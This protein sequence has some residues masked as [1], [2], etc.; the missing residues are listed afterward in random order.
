MA[1]CGAESMEE[2][3]G[4]PRN[5]D[6]AGMSDKI[7]KVRTPIFPTYPDVEAVLLSGVGYTKSEVFGVFQAIRSQAGTPQNPVDWSEPQI[8]I[9]QRLQGIPRQV[10]E[11]IWSRSQ[12]KSNPR[13]VYGAYMLCTGHQFW[14]T[15]SDGR[16]RISAKGQLFLDRES[17][18]LRELDDLEGLLELLRILSLKDAAQRADLMPEW[19]QFLKDY[20]RF[21]SAATVKD[22]LRRRLVNLLER[23]LISRSGNSYSITAEGQNWLAD[24][25]DS[26]VPGE[27]L[28]QAVRAYNEAQL[29]LLRE[30][31]SSMDPYRFEHLIRDLLEA[32]GYEDVTVTKVSGDKGVD[33]LATAQFGITTVR[34]VVQVKRY[35]GRIGRPVLDQ[36]R[37]ALHYH[38]AIRGTIISLGTFSKDCSA[39]ALFSGAAPIGLIDGPKL[40]ELLVKH[41]VGVQKRPLIL[42]EFDPSYF[43]GT[44][45]DDDQM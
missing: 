18:T 7:H 6:F 45:P 9:P 8:W 23:G 25:M 36:L 24:Q 19:M 17:Q 30:H 27:E 43:Q 29:A 3:R 12:H 28:V 11:Q 5:L 20:S 44:S 21:A 41:E 13:H 35:Q 15:R 2:Q 1:P 39:A 26:K 10:A 31:L 42:H 4:A 22:A 37:G 14:E 32:M 34:E 40:L 38:Q 33:V 16:L